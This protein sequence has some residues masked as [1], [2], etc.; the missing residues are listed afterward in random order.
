[1]LFPRSR[2]LFL[3]TTQRA[4]G[5]SVEVELLSCRMKPV[6]HNGR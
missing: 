3:W 1:M 6:Y 5:G 2:P 4:V